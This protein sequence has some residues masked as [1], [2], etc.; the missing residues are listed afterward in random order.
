MVNW[1][2]PRPEATDLCRA[3]LA[4]GK[5]AAARL[6]CRDGDE[7]FAA[8]PA[9]DKVSLSRLGDSFGARIEAFGQALTA[10]EVAHSAGPIA[11]LV[12]MTANSQE[13]VLLALAAGPGL[14]RGLDRVHRNLGR[15]E[16]MTAGFLLD[17][18][19]T[20][21]DTRLVLAGALHPEAPLRQ[22]GLLTSPAPGAVSASTPIEV[23]PAV[24]A[25]LRGEEIPI[26]LGVEAT[27][28][29]A[30]PVLAGELADDL[31]LPPLRPGELALLP[32]A[33]PVA[34]PLLAILA[35]TGGDKL[36]LTGDYDGDRLHDWQRDARLANALLAV[37]LDRA[38]ARVD[39]TLR[40]CLR[41]VSRT[42]LPLAAW[43]AHPIGPLPDDLADRITRVDCDRAVERERLDRA[44]AR[45][46]D[47]PAVA[48][49]LRR[50]LDQLRRA[51]G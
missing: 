30:D 4:L 19:A 12:T 39:D 28:F 29:D 6:T 37:D 27:R 47:A 1:T 42:D 50:Y 51:A 9:T 33:A 20:G 8:L 2:R 49:S 11:R 26:P 22:Q 25:A 10:A 35:M 44:A 15:G 21:E 43:S 17:L 41:L 18:A 24:L 5:A 16:Q 31:N 3:I 32:A 36:W 14:D 48:G 40:R 13:L 23:A 7:G 45:L 34:R 46:A 38:G